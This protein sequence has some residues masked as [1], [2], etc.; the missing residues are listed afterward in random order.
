MQAPPPRVNGEWE[1]K[2]AYLD[3]IDRPLSPGEIFMLLLLIGCFT[4]CIGL[5]LLVA[6]SRGELTGS[7]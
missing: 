4:V 7:L 1:S 3:P 5:V 6:A 2:S